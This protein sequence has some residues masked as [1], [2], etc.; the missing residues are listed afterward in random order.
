MTTDFENHQRHHDKTN[1]CAFLDLGQAGHTL[2]S[3]FSPFCNRTF[4][5]MSHT[6]GVHVKKSN[7]IYKSN[8]LTLKCTTPTPLVLNASPDVTTP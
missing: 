4:S 7:G 6:S 8:E 1:L 2:Q 5:P 3:L